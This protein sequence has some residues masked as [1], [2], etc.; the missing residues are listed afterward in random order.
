MFGK[1]QRGV[2]ERPNKT[3]KPLIPAW[4][5]IM[6]SVLFAASLLAGLTL[7]WQP[8]EP[9]KPR[10]QV[11]SE[12]HQE[13]TNQEYRFY[14]LLPK[15]QVTPIPEQAIPET[16]TEAAVMIVEI[17]DAKPEVSEETTKSEQASLTP[18]EEVKPSYFLQ[19][20]SYQDPDSAD[21]RRAEIILNGLSADILVSI[22]NGQTWYRVVSGPYDS[23]E[24][25][26]IAQQNLQNGGIDSIVVKN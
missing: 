10:G 3:K 15:Q 21:A 22:E 18:T 24:A 17:P 6:V 11:T 1:T 19:V 13:D 12:H 4:L 20:R 2:S 9:V 7:F 23:Q 16:E 25:A 26:V 5:S 14:D 8:W